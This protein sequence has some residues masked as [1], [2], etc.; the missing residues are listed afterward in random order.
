MSLSKKMIR[1]S[2]WMVGMNWTMRLIGIVNMMIL[3][4]LLT[5]SDFGLFSMAI[6]FMFLFNTDLLLIGIN[7]I[8]HI[9]WVFFSSL[10]AMFAFAALT[11][12]FFIVKN[13]WFEGILLAVV[14]FIL[15]RADLMAKW[16]NGGELAKY[17]S[18]VGALLLFGF[19]FLLQ[20]NRQR[21]M[22]AQPVG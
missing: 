9:I 12:R 15:L 21:R 13:K 20:K 4:R 11:Q 17:I 3:A 6:V 16:F 5:P 1:G 10:A 14:T 19:I 2:A 8:F 7:N 22:E 18:G